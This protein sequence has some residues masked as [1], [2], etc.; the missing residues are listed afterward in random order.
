MILSF[1]GLRLPWFC[2]LR[3]LWQSQALSNSLRHEHGEKVRQ[4]KRIFP[5]FSKAAFT[6][7]ICRR[8]NASHGQ[9][10]SLL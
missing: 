7:A 2:L 6:Q 10:F 1:L 9:L 3:Y 5:L 4:V 8:K